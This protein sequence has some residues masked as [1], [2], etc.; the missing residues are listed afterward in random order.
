VQEES[1]ES[2]GP[3]VQEERPKRRREPESRERKTPDV[4]VSQLIEGATGLLGQPSWVAAGALREHDPDEM[5][6]I[7]AAKREVDRFLKAPVKTG[8]EE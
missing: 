8:E 6:S 1:T 3:P 2:A 7:D 4:P 5:M